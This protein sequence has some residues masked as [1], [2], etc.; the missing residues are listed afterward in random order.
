MDSWVCFDKASFRLTGTIKI[1]KGEAIS[2]DA[3]F[4]R[5][6]ERKRA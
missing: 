3:N 6:A 1:P 4:T 2:I 5:K